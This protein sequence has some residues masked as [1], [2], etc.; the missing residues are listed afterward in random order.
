M[1]EWVKKA[2][3]ALAERFGGTVERNDFDSWRFAIP[4]MNGIRYIDVR[5]I[6]GIM[7]H[8]WP[9]GWTWERR[10]NSYTGSNSVSVADIGGWRF[11]SVDDTG[12]I[13]EDLT[14][15][16][17]G[18]WGNIYKTQD[19]TDRINKARQACGMEALK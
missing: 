8:F 2:R 4:T 11:P 13:V 17:A 15:L 5:D 12:T 1:S 6:D 9:E 19:E 18:V 3:A 10:G 16:T 14:R 7:L